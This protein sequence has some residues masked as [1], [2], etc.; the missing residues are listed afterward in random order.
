MAQPLQTTEQTHKIQRS[1]Q[2]KAPLQ[3]VGAVKIATAPTDPAVLTV[4]TINSAQAQHKTP[5]TLV[6]IPM[7]LPVRAIKTAMPLLMDLVLVIRLLSPRRKALVKHV[8]AVKLLGLTR[9][10]LDSAPALRQ[11]HMAQATDM[12][13]TMAKM[14]NHAHYRTHCLVTVRM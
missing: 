12:A 8:L 14:L 3:I 11:T 2:V 4:L 13:P 6:R 10:T 5:S 9:Q 7:H 1:R